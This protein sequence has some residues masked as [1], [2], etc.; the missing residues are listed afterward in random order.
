MWGFTT[1][2]HH[3]HYHRPVERGCS[4]LRP[5]ARGTRKWRSGAEQC[6]AAAAERHPAAP[7]GRTTRSQPQAPQTAT[8]TRGRCGSPRKVSEKSKKLFFAKR[9]QNTSDFFSLVSFARGGRWTRRAR[10]SNRTF[11]GCDN[12]TFFTPHLLRHSFSFVRVCLSF[13]R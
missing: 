4:L 6:V 5:C 1:E 3:Q 7:R 9:K 8:R 11:P 2:D 13:E 12:I 10:I